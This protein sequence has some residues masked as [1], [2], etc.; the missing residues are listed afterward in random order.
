MRSVN[1]WSS[2]IVVIA[3]TLVRWVEGLAAC[4]GLQLSKLKHRKVK[5]LFNYLHIY[6]IIEFLNYF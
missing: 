2:E 3:A 4:Y 5:F 1:R 6:L